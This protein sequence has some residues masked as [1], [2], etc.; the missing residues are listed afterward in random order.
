MKTQSLDKYVS[1]Y[2]FTYA[3]NAYTN[4]CVLNR[5]HVRMHYITLHYMQGTWE[6]NN[7]RTKI[8]DIDK[9]ETSG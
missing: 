6:N 9:N 5:Q 1:M 7:K 4:M 8:I 2:H 3:I